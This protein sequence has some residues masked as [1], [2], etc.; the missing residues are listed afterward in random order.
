MAV[1]SGAPETSQNPSRSAV[2]PPLTAEEEDHIILARITNDERPLRRVIKKFHNYTSVA[3]TPVVPAV[4]PAEDPATTADDARE[5]FLVEL[6][7]FQLSLKKSVMICDAEARQ[8]EEYQRERQRID[9]EHGKLRGQIE[10]LKTALEEA[11]MIRRRK[12]D[13]DLVAEKVNTLPSRDELEQS[14]QALENDMAAIRSE[15][16]TQNRTIQGQKSAL[17][18]IISELGSL[19]FM[20]K[21]IDVSSVVPTPRATPV[22]DGNATDVGDDL[23]EGGTALVDSDVIEEKEEGEEDKLLTTSATRTVAGETIED[24]IEMGEVEED[25]KNGRGKKKLREELEEGE[26]S[27]TSSALSDPPDDD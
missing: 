16:E 8:V 19:R 6:A 13:Y 25:P 17:D 21:D 23:T 7:T 27:D 15:H 1:S 3:Y 11:Q 22:P 10:Q 26:A 18:G 5:A 2:V 20:G 9:D 14:I 12:I 24:D 4:V